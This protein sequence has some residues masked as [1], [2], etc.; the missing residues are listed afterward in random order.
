MRTPKRTSRKVM[1]A[2]QA[3]GSRSKISALGLTLALISGSASAYYCAS[4]GNPMAVN[5]LNMLLQQ[6][7][8]VESAALRALDSN[9]SLGI[10][11]QQDD[12]T[13]AIKILTKQEAVSAQGISDNA[14]KNAQSLV[15]AYQ[16]VKQ[17]EQMKKA[18]FEFGAHGQAFKA[19]EVLSD[20]E[21]AQQDNKS[22]DSSILNKV[23]SEVI[24]APGVYMN[25][26]KAQEAML[27]AHNEFCTTSQA[28]SGLCGAAGENA[29]LSLQ[30]STLFTTAAPDTA[31]ARA[32][33]ALINNMVGLPDA[34]IDG[35][36]AKTSAGQDY[37]MAKLSKDA[38]TS[39]A[40]TSLKAIQA[41]YSPV[42]GGG[43]NSHDSSTKLAP[44]QHLEKSVARYLGSGQDYKD[45]A[46]SQAIKDERGLMVD[47]LIQGTE[48]LNLQYQQYK[49]NERKEAVLAALVSAESKLSDG[50]IE[51]TDR[52]KSTGNI[53][54]I[55]L[56]Q[57]MA[58]K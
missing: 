22:A 2:P 27:Q 24:A 32:Q 57:A 13:T 19:C 54:R 28:A 43:T 39:P 45:F 53:R 1:K 12:V 44:M 31:M 20:R 51:V 41:Q 35:K 7:D 56:A 36:I 26:H 6:A 37:V 17:S 10:K 40:I 23:G 49:S 34:P 30:A 48:R 16:A 5:T 46:K 15:T 18:Q 55:A 11:K 21:Q 29:S 58:S 38:L 33:N 9:L 25:P 42:A 3:H 8:A 50:S 52:S 4:V 14:H 47:G